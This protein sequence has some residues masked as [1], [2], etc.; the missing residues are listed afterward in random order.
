MDKN[1]ETLKDPETKRPATFIAGGIKYQGADIAE[2]CAI[3]IQAAEQ[4]FK[5]KNIEKADVEEVVFLF[6]TDKEF[7]S[8]SEWWQQF[9]K[10]AAAYSKEAT[11]LFGVKKMPWAV[12]RSK[13]LKS[14]SERGQ[15]A[16][17]ELI[18]ILNKDAGEGY[19]HK[20]DDPDLWSKH[21][22]DTAEAISVRNWADLVKSLKDDG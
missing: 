13:H 10:N 6:Q 15:P 5:Q 20:H 3:A 22:S 16:I 19:N 4:A 21:G 17:H 1:I 11:G 7:E 12:I 14:V 9:S 2:K 8:G 18:H